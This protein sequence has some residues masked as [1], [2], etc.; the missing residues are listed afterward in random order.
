V[1]R[2]RKEIISRKKLSKSHVNEK[3]QQRPEPVDHA[4]FNARAKKL[5]FH[6]VLFVEKIYS[7]KHCEI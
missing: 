6:V 5:I 2:E 4:E 1:K 3:F 7:Q